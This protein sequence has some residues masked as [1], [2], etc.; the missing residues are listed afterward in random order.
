MLDRNCFFSCVPMVYSMTRLYA[1]ARVCVC[2]GVWFCLCEFAYSFLLPNAHAFYMCA[3][4]GRLK[5]W[6]CVRPSVHASDFIS[7]G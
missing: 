5:R 1:R 2:V 7:G 4:K 3:P 6:F